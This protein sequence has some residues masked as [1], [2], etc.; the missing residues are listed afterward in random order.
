MT[1]FD[2]LKRKRLGDILVDEGIATEE[3]VIAALQEQQQ[4]GRLLTDILF[5]GRQ[6]SEYQIAR[7]VVE[8]YQTPFIDLRSYT[9]HKD[10]VTSYPAKLLHRAAV[11]PLERFGKQVCFAC[12]EIPS[13]DIADKLKESSPGGIYIYV[14]SAVDIRHSLANYAPLAEEE[15]EEADAR[16]RPVATA[17]PNED[18]AWKE[19]FDAANESIL[20]DLSDTPGGE[21]D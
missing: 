18:Q 1:H 12:Q 6:V 20:T 9:L 8:Q 10:L 3:E 19:L 17:V 13:D 14:A 2:R 4:T 15:A 5:D 11:I 21:D 7:A 16:E